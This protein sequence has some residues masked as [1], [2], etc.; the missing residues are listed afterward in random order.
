[1]GLLFEFGQATPEI[2]EKSVFGIFLQFSGNTHL[3]LCQK[4]KIKNPPFYLL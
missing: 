4:S 2:P 3:E 1:M